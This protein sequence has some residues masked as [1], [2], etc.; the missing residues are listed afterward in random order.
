MHQTVTFHKPNLP[1]DADA[2]Y[3][4][5]QYMHDLNSSQICYVR[6]IPNPTRGS[7]Q[8]ADSS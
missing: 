6:P 5:M 1:V 8:H 4:A 2:R 3:N 7:T